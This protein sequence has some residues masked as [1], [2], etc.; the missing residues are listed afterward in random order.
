M[1]LLT[2]SGFLYDWR[3]ERLVWN[4]RSRCNGDRAIFPK[5]MDESGRDVC[6]LHV[7]SWCRGLLVDCWVSILE[8]SIHVGNYRHIH[9]NANSCRVICRFRIW[10]VEIAP[11]SST[12]K[13][14]DRSQPSVRCEIVTELP[15]ARSTWPFGHEADR[16]LVTINQFHSQMLRDTFPNGISDFDAF[17]LFCLLHN[18]RPILQTP[19]LSPRDG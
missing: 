12:N 15:G 9:R 14:L 5:Q 1:A 11:I 10:V 4:F 7:V 17:L 13:M 2:S 3:C 6:G 19:L 8:P 18:Y 16:D